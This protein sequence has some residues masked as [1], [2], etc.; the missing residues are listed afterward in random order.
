MGF[1]IVRNLQHQLGGEP[2]YAAEVASKI[3]A[4]DLT[5]NVQTKAGD[6]SSVLAS[7]KEMQNKLKAMITKVQNNADQVLITA[8][9]VA[10]A[11]TQVAEG[12]RYQS[13]AASSMAASVEQMTVSIDQ[14][15]SNAEEAKVISTHA[16]ELSEKGAGVIQS[17]VV[18][19]GH[20]ESSVKESATVIEGLQNQ[21][22]GITNIV[23]VIKEIA[24]QTNLLALNAAI[25]AARA[26]EQG[27][28]FAVVAD[29]V[30]KLAERTGNST[31]EIASMIGNIQS[32]TR[33]TVT[34]ME[35]GASKVTGGVTLAN[36]AVESIQKI[37]TETN[38][39]AQVITDISNSLKEQSSASRDIA[40]NVEKIAQMSEEN[41]AAVQHT[42]RAAH[43]LEELASSLQATIVLFKV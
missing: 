20:I 29:E 4:G 42:S 14:V 35:V 30:R 26:G 38:R 34:S 9:E 24:D 31:R 1:F 25:E 41:S 12:S 36:H 28:G 32:A 27:R 18:E 10:A 7:M 19:M 11:S 5:M 22:E 43:H 39:V 6:A 33:E 15:S 21:A 23:N 13:E 37:Q 8:T 40:I 2:A 17:A 16:G 3:A